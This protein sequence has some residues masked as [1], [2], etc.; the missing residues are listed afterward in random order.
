MIRNATVN[1]ID[2]ISLISSLTWKSAYKDIFDEPTIQEIIRDLFNPD[3]IKTR[4]IHT[5]YLVAEVDGYIVGYANY[6]FRDKDLYIIAIYVLDSHQREGV[7]HELVEAV[8]KHAEHQGVAY[9]DIKNGNVSA[10]AFYKKEGFEQFICI[11]DT[12]YNQ[13]LKTLRLA[14]MINASQ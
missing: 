4:L 6:E 1:D 2:A 3:F 5:H 11:P 7:G 9:V 12:M 14:K 10:E 8:L 13:P